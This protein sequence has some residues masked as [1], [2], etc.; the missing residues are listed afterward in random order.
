MSGIAIEGIEGVE[1]GVGVCQAARGVVDRRRVVDAVAAGDG[2]GAL[3]EVGV[4]GGD[5]V[6]GRI[7]GVGDG[8]DIG[9]AVTDE[10]IEGLKLAGGA[11]AK[12]A[13][14][15]G[16]PA[17]ADVVFADQ[18]SN[19]ERILAAQRN[20]HGNVG[21]AVGGGIDHV[22]GAATPSSVTRL[23]GNAGLPLHLLIV[24]AEQLG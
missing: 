22:R 6:L 7:A 19:L 23:V 17:G 14:W 21:S 13:G 8:G 1:R 15:T 4:Q 18:A 20:R 11:G 2:K 5:V 9:A 16:G 12:A 3:V 10:V 24:V